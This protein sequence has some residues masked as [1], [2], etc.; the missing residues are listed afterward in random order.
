[1][2]PLK[3]TREPDPMSQT[4]PRS[5]RQSTE[6][7]AHATILVVDDDPEN[8]W[9]VMTILSSAGAQVAE[10]SSAAAAL[11]A[12]RQNPPDLV[13]SD[14]DM[15]GEDGCVL[16]QRIR[17][18]SPEAGGLIPAIALTA[19]SRADEVQRALLAGFTAHLG[20]PA[21]ALELINIAL[22]LTVPR[23]P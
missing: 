9:F 10:A 1:M 2:V 16:I 23:Q 11:A 19:G 14:I 15:P 22:A 20:K 21:S 17:C 6:A 5:R 18:L 12:V 13:V 4:L 8:R 7:L 3:Q